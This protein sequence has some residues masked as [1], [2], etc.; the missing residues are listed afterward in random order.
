MDIFVRELHTSTNST[1]AAS[2]HLSQT[3]ANYH[4]DPPYKRSNTF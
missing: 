2:K 4:E 1:T 3:A